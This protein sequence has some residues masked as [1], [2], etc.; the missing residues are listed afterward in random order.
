MLCHSRA[1]EGL[2]QHSAPLGCSAA[3]VRVREPSCLFLWASCGKIELFFERYGC[4]GLLCRTHACEGAE[5]P[6][7]VC[8]RLPSPAR[9]RGGRIVWESTWKSKEGRRRRGRKGAS[10]HTSEK[11]GHMRACSAAKATPRPIKDVS[12]NRPLPHTMRGSTTTK[13]AKRRFRSWGR[14]I[15]WWRRSTCWRRRQWRQLHVGNSSRTGGGARRRRRVAGEGRVGG[16]EGQRRTG[17]RSQGKTK[18]GG[19]IRK[20]STVGARIGDSMKRNE[21]LC[22]RGRGTPRWR[23]G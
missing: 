2:T 11:R 16:G 22:L 8:I 4:F 14:R 19:G 23:E 3:L 15:G 7:T 21:P 1:C 10:E 9:S 6:V 18:R 17:R 5:L 13:V 20:W 12:C